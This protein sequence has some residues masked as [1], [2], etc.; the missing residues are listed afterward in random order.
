[1]VTYLSYIERV[2]HHAVLG[3]IPLSALGLYYIIKLMSQIFRNYKRTAQTTLFIILIIFIS[4]MSLIQTDN[5][6][7]LPEDKRPINE[8]LI[9]SVINEKDYNAIAYLGSISSKQSVIAESDIS[10][11]VYPISKNYV[12]ATGQNI[13]EG[14]GGGNIEDVKTFF[15]TFS[16]VEKQI[17]AYKNNIKYI[18]TK[19]PINCEAF[20]EIYGENF[21]YIYQV[22]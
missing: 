3:L 13:K 12:L 2:R 10:V 4:V 1:S 5:G 14:F 18:L 19:K 9:T 11:A 15:S 21:R 22:K 20:N 16:C 7:Y 17:I 6:D 8:D